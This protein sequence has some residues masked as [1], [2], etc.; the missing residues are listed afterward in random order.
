[1]KINLISKY[2][3]IKLPFEVLS[4]KVF[5][6]WMIGGWIVYYVLTSIWM[7]EA[8][9]SFAVGIGNNPLIQVPFVLFLIA[10]YLNLLR[11]SMHVL[12]EGKARFVA[13]L[14]L[15][16]G[17]LLF[18][19]GFFL[20][21][22]LRES[23]KRMIGEGDIIKPPWVTGT[24]SVKDIEPGLKESLLDTEM[25]KSIFAREPEL[26]L[27]DK[28]SNSYRVGAFPPEKIDGTY[29][30][31]LDF[32]VAPGIKLYQGS[33][34]KFGGY[35]PLRVLAPGMSDFFEIEP[36][37]YRFLVS[38]EAEKVSEKAGAYTSKF[39]IRNP[40]YKTRVFMGEKV[41]AEGDPGQGVNFGN[42]RLYF[43]DQT[44]WVILE[45]AKDPGLPVLKLAILL[46]VIG[47]PLI[48]VRAIYKMSRA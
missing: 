9:G 22:F 41:I 45:A 17:V 44:Y 15:P 10:G 13:W 12:K 32:G 34:V 26:T 6:F 19:T 3:I 38:M 23:G 35:K 40:V 46:I 11:A 14:V 2:K 1:V 29:Y 16:L 25:D 8:F 30:H 4:S 5:L 33:Q 7:D 47:A 39:N 42:F 36:F 43:V 20:S 24:Y 48:L 21:L 18:F 28:G 27:T 31:I 37:P